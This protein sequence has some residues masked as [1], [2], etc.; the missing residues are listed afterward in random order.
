MNITAL[1][2]AAWM[3]LALIGVIVGL[4]AALFLSI[5]AFFWIWFSLMELPHVPRNILIRKCLSKIKG[6]GFAPT[7][8]FIYSG[9][10]VAVDGAKKRL[11]LANSKSMNIYSIEDVTKVEADFN[12]GQY[13]LTGVIRITVR[14]YENPLFEIR[15]QTFNLTR[16]RQIDSL[17]SILREPHSDS[18]S[19]MSLQSPPR[20]QRR[21]R[22]GT[23]ILPRRRH[24]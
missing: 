1:L 7:H 21:G 11:F 24:R 6:P 9:S 4:V 14:N 10:G 15:G 22:L 5:V 12:E 18:G 16:L 3:I 20:A 2:S 23:H 8:Q 19:A 13:K 17:L